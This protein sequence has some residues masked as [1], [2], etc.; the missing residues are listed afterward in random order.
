MFSTQ[1]TARGP[2]S[3]SQATARAIRYNMDYRTRMMEEAL[4]L[5]Q[6]D[7]ANFDLLP[8]ITA[9][10]GYTSRSNEAFGYGF[11]TDGKVTA[12]PSASQERQ[13]ATAKAGI[14]WSILDFGLSY[15][16]AKQ[17]SDQAMVADE[18]RRKAMQNLV[19]DVRQAFW[20]AYAAQ[21]LL[22]E[23]RSGLTPGG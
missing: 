7:V 16:R 13:I 3:L 2:I 21:Q 22:P 19:L 23:R 6:L 10:A 17:L 12:N 11:G 4:A 14:S 18:R 9:S 5:G 1:E 8:K 15:Y 20:R